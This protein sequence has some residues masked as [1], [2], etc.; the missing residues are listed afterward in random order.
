[1]VALRF[2][3]TALVTDLRIR[4]FRW[5]V[6]ADTG[7][8]S[9]MNVAVTN[10]ESVGI[11]LLSTSTGSVS[12]SMIGDATGSVATPSKCLVRENLFGSVTIEGG[13]I[14][15]NDAEGVFL[16]GHVNATATGATMFTNRV[17]FTWGS[18]G[19]FTGKALTI[20]NNTTLQVAVTDGANELVKCEF[21]EDAG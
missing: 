8:L 4:G 15:F 7:A 11:A 20:T 6:V 12:L 21:L 16:G 17:G 10:S 9:F 19:A 13:S 3:G 1:T 5:G 18:N 2:A 14:S